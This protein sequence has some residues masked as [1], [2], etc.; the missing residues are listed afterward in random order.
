VVWRRDARSLRRMRKQFGAEREARIL[1]ERFPGESRGS[2]F[3]RE[4]RSLVDSGNER[5]AARDLQTVSRESVGGVDALRGFQI[6]GWNSG[7]RALL[8]TSAKKMPVLSI[9]LGDAAL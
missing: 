7:A 8:E 3:L 4:V 6:A 2:F 9:E 1:V 5:S